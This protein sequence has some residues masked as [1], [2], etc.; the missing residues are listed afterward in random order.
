[1]MHWV[2]A[3]GELFEFP[4]LSWWILHVIAIVVIFTLGCVY[5]QKWAAKHAQKP[6]ATPES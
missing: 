2:L 3:N 6:P 1:M 4:G 5:G